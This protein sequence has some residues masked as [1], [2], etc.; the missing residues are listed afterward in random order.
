MV[1]T[2]NDLNNIENMLVNFNV[3]GIFY[4]DDNDTHGL[5]C[6]YREFI[7]QLENG[8]LP[9]LRHEQTYGQKDYF[10]SLVVG[11]YTSNYIIYAIDGSTYGAFGEDNQFGG[12]MG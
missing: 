6:T 2:S 4:I 5:N 9:I 1:I 10:Y 8:N 11:V 7:T 3:N 12:L